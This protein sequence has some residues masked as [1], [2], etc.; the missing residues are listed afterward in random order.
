V[1]ELARFVGS[2]GPRQIIL[3]DGALVHLAP[4]LPPLRLMPLAERVF[5]FPDTD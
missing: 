4:E 5:A 1:A 2:Y 3:E